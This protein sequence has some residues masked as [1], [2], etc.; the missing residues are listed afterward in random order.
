MLKRL[1]AGLT[2]AAGLMGAGFDWHLPQGFPKPVVPADN[3]MSPVK[4]VFMVLATR[5]RAEMADP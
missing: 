5:V 1:T 3:A 4:V 2:V